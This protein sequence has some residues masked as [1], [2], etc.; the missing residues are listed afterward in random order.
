MPW[1]YTSFQREI[2]IHGTGLNTHNEEGKSG[3]HGSSC[4]TPSMRIKALLLCRDTRS[5][6]LKGLKKSQSNEYMQKERRVHLGT[7]TSEDGATTTR[8]GRPE[9]RRRRSVIHTEISETNTH[10]RRYTR[11]IA[12]A[13]GKGRGDSVALRGREYISWRTGQGGEK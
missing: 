2:F 4:S 8:P 1:C 5:S 3:E 10:T 12:C 9:S 7:R 6:M 13:I 11:R